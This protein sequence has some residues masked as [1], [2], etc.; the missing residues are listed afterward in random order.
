MIVRRHGSLFAVIFAL[1]AAAGN[2]YSAPP[3]P[4]G[5]NPD[6]TPARLF[7]WFDTLGYPDLAQA[8][9]GRI[10]TG[11]WRQING[12]FEP[13]YAY[14]FLLAEGDGTFTVWALHSLRTRRLAA[15]PPGTSETDRIGFD[16]WD[17]AGYIDERL[18]QHSEPKT[19]SP[20]RPPAVPSLMP[21]SERGQLFLLARVAALRKLDEQAA[22]LMDIVA[23]LPPSKWSGSGAD[24]SLRRR[25]ADDLAYAETWTT[26]QDFGDRDVSRGQLLARL[27]RVAAH[28]PDCPDHTELVATVAG[29]RR[30]IREDEA[31]ATR[32]TER[33]FAQW[34]EHDQIAELIY[35]LRNLREES[36][37]WSSL[38]DGL[39]G[40]P[41]NEA[42]RLIERG[43]AA[44]P[45]LVEAI[46]DDGPT[47]VDRSFPSVDNLKWPP[48]VGDA[49]IEAVRRIAGRPF[50][51]DPPDRYNLIGAAKRR[52]EQRLIRA[53]SDD[54]RV[55]GEKAV[56]IDAARRGGDE[57]CAIARRLVKV[58]P[59]EAA[60][61]IIEG[62]GKTDDSW[63]DSMISTLVGVPGDA[64]DLYLM[65]L[66][67][68]DKRVNDAVAAA[69]TLRQRGSD[70]WLPLMIER[71]NRFNLDTAGDENRTYFIANDAEQMAELLL[72]AGTVDGIQAVAARLR[73]MPIR[74]RADIVRIPGARRYDI[75]RLA[76]KV[77]PAYAEYEQALL[78]F[79]IEAM[80]DDRER[81]T[82]ITG[83][84]KELR[85]VAD[86]AATT[87]DLMTE[88]LP[89]DLQADQPTRDR[90]IAAYRTRRRETK[91]LPPPDPAAHRT[92]TAVTPD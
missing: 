62:I 52:A 19:A 72:T 11:S 47:R 18:R 79:L 34:S 36:A 12:E 67:K 64:V 50:H 26:T 43:M 68:N 46:A 87:L 71:W 91:D 10:A 9:F 20:R 74:L 53:W 21:V 65:D 78:G 59:E 76:K 66:V 54:V 14:G 44:L 23:R 16:D 4:A 8:R 27:E 49:A 45:Q 89:F 69:K 77:G 51:L 32:R 3:P 61:A 6:D 41:T 70:R 29:L 2:S 73:E 17:L 57:A 48:A 40:S 83:D 5:P 28:F 35:Q 42:E 55:R 24:R 60:A 38:R 1:L 13:I 56:M 25:I 37:T 39:N 81:S 58:A 7:T 80:A 33:P 15:T 82:D 84:L 22:R 86:V 90:Q 63:R 31:H 88:D 92:P 75:L 85:R 30:Q